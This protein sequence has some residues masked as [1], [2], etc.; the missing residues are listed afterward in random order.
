MP[1]PRVARRHSKGNATACSTA[2][3]LRCRE[4]VNAMEGVRADSQRADDAMACH[5]ICVTPIRSGHI[6]ELLSERAHIAVHILRGLPP[7]APR[8]FDR[9]IF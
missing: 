9:W 1:I 4:Q 2:Q 3:R 6:C 7:T 5:D 8:G